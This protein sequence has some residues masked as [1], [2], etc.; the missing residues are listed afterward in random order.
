MKSKRVSVAGR[1]VKGRAGQRERNPCH[2]RLEN[3]MIR[4]KFL[5]LKG[6]PSICN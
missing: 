4:K 3:A 5:Q 1:I 6:L 2:G